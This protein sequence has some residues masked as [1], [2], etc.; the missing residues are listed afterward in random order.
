MKMRHDLGQVTG[1]AVRRRGVMNPSVIARTIRQ[2]AQDAVLT[3]LT[4]AP[5]SPEGSAAPPRT[6]WLAHKHGLAA[7]LDAYESHPLRPRH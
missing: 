7:M 4:A 1:Q 2:A 6:A 3:L 5:D